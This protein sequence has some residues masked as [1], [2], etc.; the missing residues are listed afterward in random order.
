MS[1][2]RETPPVDVEAELLEA[3]PET[4]GSRFFPWLGR[5]LGQL[6][7]F[8]LLAGAVYILWRE[9]H[10]LSPAEVADAIRAWGWDSVAMALALSASSF[11]LMGFVEFMG[12]RWAG[13]RL[14]LPSVLLGSF[15][16][17]AMAHS[18]GANLLVSGAVRARYYG[19]MGV[20]LQ[21]TAA[22][23]VFQSFSFTAG[24]LALAGVSLLIAG[25]DEIARVSQIPVPVANG[26]GIA[27]VVGVA[28]YITA[29]RFVRGTVRIFGHGVTLPTMPVAAAQIAL[30]ALDNA[31]A[32]AILW[33]L[34]PADEVGFAT[35][36]GAFAPSVAIGL[37]SH[38]PG[39][40]G[41]FEGAMS[42]LLGGVDPAALAAGFLG[43]RLFFFVIPLAIA[44][45]ALALDTLAHRRAA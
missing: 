34:L 2:S 10:D 6:L 43:Y 44:G 8:L 18:L 27:L 25:S 45:I 3:L 4:Q 14:P 1:R 32:A 7:A 13:A 17:S 33:V 22:I 16:A 26:I 11:I 42:T 5:V 15:M 37:A 29:C 9:F 23:T 24:L 31:V 19:R 39:G 12:L 35:F 30:G 38:V 28:V 40:V 36:V 41:V 20:S 21:Q